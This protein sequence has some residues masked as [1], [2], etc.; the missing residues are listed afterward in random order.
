[1]IR[2]AFKWVGDLHWVLSLKDSNSVLRD[3]VLAYIGESNQ[4]PEARHAVLGK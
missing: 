4:V 3:C 1:M 2:I